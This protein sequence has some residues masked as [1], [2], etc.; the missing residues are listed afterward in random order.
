MLGLLVVVGLVACRSTPA[1][2]TTPQGTVAY[3]SEDALDAIGALQHAAIN[4]RRGNVIPTAT[5]RTVV[6][7]TMA[8]AATINT[9]IDNGTGATAAYRDAI[10][11][12]TNAQKTLSADQHKALDGY[13]A[14]A[15]GILTALGGA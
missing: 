14:T 5:M 11:G 4:A 3:Q 7:A 2:I 13:F 1:T 8:A 6:K 10:T 9:A 15:V 12:L